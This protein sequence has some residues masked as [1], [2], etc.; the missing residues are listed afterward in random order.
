M[1]SKKRIIVDYKTLPLDVLEAIAAKYPDGYSD[2]DIIRFKNA[3]GDA[4]SAIR[5]ETDETIYMIKVSVQL[6]TMMEEYDSDDSEEDEEDEYEEVEVE[7]E[8][9]S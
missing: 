6:R 4:I 3:K 8:M 2:N 7:E 5:L 1:D 9:E